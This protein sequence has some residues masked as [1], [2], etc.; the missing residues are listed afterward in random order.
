VALRDR[1][2]LSHPPGIRQVLHDGGERFLEWTLG[3]F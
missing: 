3:Q 1:T 2:W